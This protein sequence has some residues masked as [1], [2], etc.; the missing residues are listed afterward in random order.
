M[1]KKELKQRMK[2]FCA[3]LVQN[4]ELSQTWFPQQFTQEELDYL[5][6]IQM[7]IVEKVKD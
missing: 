7:R 3:A 4:A 6:S 5:F 1:K 2:D